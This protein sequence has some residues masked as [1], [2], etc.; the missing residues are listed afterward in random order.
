MQCRQRTRIAPFAAK[1]SHSPPK[2]KRPSVS[3]R[4]YE[5]TL[6]LLR[7]Q[8]CLAARMR[9]CEIARHLGKDPAWVSRTVRKLLSEKATAYATDAERATLEEMRRDYDRLIATAME[10]KETGSD[11]GKLA[12]IQTASAALRAKH[13]FLIKTGLVQLRDVPTEAPANL[14]KTPMAGLDEKAG[15]QDADALLIAMADRIRGERGD[16]ISQEL[17]P[18]PMFPR[19]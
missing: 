5:A 14:V 18:L 3:P 2:Q 13:D 4:K 7:V 6:D 12:A 10:M 1:A 15:K 16:S 8:D 17:T 9:P 19:F 11:K